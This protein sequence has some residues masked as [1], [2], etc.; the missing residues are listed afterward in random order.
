MRKTYLLFLSICISSLNAQSDLINLNNLYCNVSANGS[1]FQNENAWGLC[2]IQ[3]SSFKSVMFTG[4]LWMAAEV[5]NTLYTAAQEYYLAQDANYSSSDF[6]FGPVAD[7][8]S[9]SAYINRYDRVWKIDR[10]TID[11]HI[12]SYSNAGYQV[13]DEILEWPVHGDTSN[14]E[15]WLLAPFADLNNNQLYEPLLGEYPKIRGDQSIYCI[16]N[17][18]DRHQPRTN[19]NEMGVEVHLQVYA[20]NPGMLVPLENSIFFSYQIINRSNTNYEEFYAGQWYDSDL[21]HSFDDICGS[22]SSLAL[23]YTYNADSIDDPGVAGF[24]FN[25]PAVGFSLLNGNPG[26]AMYYH[27]S[28]GFMGPGAMTDTILPNHWKNFLVNHWKDGSHLSLEGPSGLYN[29]GNGDGFDT[30]S[31]AQPTNWAYNDQ[32]NWYCAPNTLS[33]K[34]QLLNVAPQALAA[35][36]T[37]CINMLLSYARDL[38]DMNPFAAVTKLKTEVPAVKSFWQAQNYSCSENYV[39]QSESQA[40]SQTELYPN[41]FN[42]VVNL[43]LPFNQGGSYTLYSLEGKKLLEGQFRGANPQLDFSELEGGMYCLVLKLKGSE[44]LQSFRILKQA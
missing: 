41:P 5:N 20:F 39:S 44:E 15:A 12:Q 8:Q 1:L 10:A 38:S 33:D 42:E 6:H 16:F 9:L 19:L 26:G 43:S 25:P 29:N 40:I 34:R 3:N 23:S 18:S 17:E 30:S 24:G 4:H 7:D 14:G 21:G 28:G 2:N 27:N 11:Q 13:P 37:L 35:G 31:T 22:D 32:E 36:D